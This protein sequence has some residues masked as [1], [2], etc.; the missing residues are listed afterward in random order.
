MTTR[1]TKRPPRKIRSE[2]LDAAARGWHVTFGGITHSDLATRTKLEPEACLSHLRAICERGDGHL[3]GP[4]KMGLV[5]IDFETGHSTFGDTLE[6][7]FFIS[8]Q[9][10]ASRQPNE[11]FPLYR[12]RLHRGAHQMSLVTFRREVL[13]R[14]RQEPHAFHVEAPS[15]NMGETNGHPDMKF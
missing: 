9:A 3:T 14:Y 13:T 1:K 4:H 7:M 12:D 8:P 2:L 15:A 11:T 6:F 5:S 10:L